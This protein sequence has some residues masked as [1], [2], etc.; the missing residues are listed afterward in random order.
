MNKFI[1]TQ[2]RRIKSDFKRSWSR[3]VKPGIVGWI[4]IILLVAWVLGIIP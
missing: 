3:K 1:N 2:K 4:A